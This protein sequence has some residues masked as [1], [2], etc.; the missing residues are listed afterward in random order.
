MKEELPL[1]KPLKLKRLVIDRETV[2]QLTDRELSEIQGGATGTNSAL[3]CSTES[4]QMTDPCYY[5]GR[6]T[7]CAVFN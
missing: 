4:A 1:M 7:K 6:G 2:R 5:P 3:I